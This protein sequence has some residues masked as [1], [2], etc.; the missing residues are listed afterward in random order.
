MGTITDDDPLPA[1]AIADVTVTEGDTR[2][3]RPRRS[4]STSAPR[5]AEPPSVNYATADGTAIAPGDYVARERDAQLSPPARQRRTVTVLV[6]GDVLDELDEN[7]AVNLSSPVNATI[8]DRQGL[9]TISDDDGLPSVSVNDVTVTEGNGNSVTASFTLSLNAA[10]GQTVPPSA[11]RQPT[12]RRRLRP[13]T[14][15]FP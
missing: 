3:R 13:T 6:N 8:S 11:T 12:A 14:R 4:P 15:R 2:H 7:F 1:L 9:G 10:S 5:A